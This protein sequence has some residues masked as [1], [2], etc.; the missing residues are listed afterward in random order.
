MCKLKPFIL[1]S[2]LADKD[3]KQVRKN[4]FKKGHADGKQMKRC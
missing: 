4:D 3:Y 1:S 2:E